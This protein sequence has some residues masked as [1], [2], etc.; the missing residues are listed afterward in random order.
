MAA[1]YCQQ[2]ALPPDARIA[3]TPAGRPVDLAGA[4]LPEADGLVLISSHLGQG[5]LLQDG[6][7]P[8]VLDEDDPFATDPALDPFDAANGFCEP[9][10]SSRYAADFIGRYRA[11]QAMRVER[12]DA[13]ARSL[14]AQKAAARRTLKEGSAAA[15]DRARAA[16][17][18][19]MT[20]WRTDA[21]L[22]CWD[23][24]L[25]PSPRAYGSLWGGD[26]IR[27]NWG[28][29]GF[30]RLCTPESWLSNWSARSSNATMARCAPSVRQPTCMIRYLGD[31]SVFDTEANRL[32]AL[33]TRTRI[34]RHDVP[35]NHHGRPVAEGEPEGRLR[36][37]E[38]VRDWLSTTRFG[39]G[40]R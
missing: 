36:A 28:S 3:R 25:E 7:D 14:L 34:E 18:P 30:G 17:S 22:R 31:N 9:P 32:E 2:A 5:P 1:F 33:F 15:S 19:V 4:D 13:R 21:D 35:G 40:A 38:I 6:L 11:A 24:S 37:G 39:T 8:S 27:S 10:R 23:L 16:W 26:P 29:V 12:L 20:I